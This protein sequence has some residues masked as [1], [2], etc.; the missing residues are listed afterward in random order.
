MKKFTFAFLA[1]LLATLNVSAAFAQDD[2]QPPVEV[3]EIGNE[4]MEIEPSAWYVAAADAIGVSIED[5]SSQ[6]TIALVAKENGVRAKDVILAVQAVAL[7]EAAALIEEENLNDRK[8]KRL[9][10]RVKRAARKFVRTEL[11]DLSNADIQRIR[12]ELNRWENYTF[13][14]YRPCFCVV[15]EFDVEPL[16]YY[17]TV[18]NGEAV[19]V[20]KKVIGFFADDQNPEVREEEMIVELDRATSGYL[21]ITLDDVIQTAEDAELQGVASL[22]AEYD[23]M[24]GY[25]TLLSIDYNSMIADEE[26]HFEISE[27][28]RTRN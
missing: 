3:I 19:K 14:I 5:L 22:T 2:T 16:T 15:D 20:E 4:I 9:E 6:P 1:V 26:L 7:E 17:V 8:A 13:K 11:G 18:E 12:W 21:F 27:V 25:P 24:R 10:N 23:T 28:R